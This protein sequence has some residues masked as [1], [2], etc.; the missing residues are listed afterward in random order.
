MPHSIP[1]DY[2]VLKIRSTKIYNIVTLQRR[3]LSL[4]LY[5]LY[6]GLLRLQILLYAGNVTIEIITLIIKI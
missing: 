5:M 4:F 2:N 6:F 3:C 1:F